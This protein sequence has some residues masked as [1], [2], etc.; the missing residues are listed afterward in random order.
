MR[1]DKG[2]K[3]IPGLT[4]KNAEILQRIRN[5]SLNLTGGGSYFDGS[6][7]NLL[8]MSKLDVAIKANENSKKIA[9]IKK[10]LNNG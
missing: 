1:K 7:V 9:N 2:H 6:D 8:S 5:N 4:L 3:T 10:S